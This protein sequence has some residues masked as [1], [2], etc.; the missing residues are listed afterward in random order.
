MAEFELFSE[1]LRDLERRGRS[2]V[3]RYEEVSPAVKHE[4]DKQLDN[5][6]NSYSSLHATAKQINVSHTLHH[7][8]GGCRISRTS[9][10][11]ITQR[12]RICIL[13][14]LYFVFVLQDR[15]RYGLKSSAR[16]GPS[17]LL[18]FNLYQ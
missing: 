15:R 4:V 3:E 5:I 10:C 14:F 11:R 17:A 7:I 2:Q 13:Y 16:A 1:S 6:R 12:R 18:H 9:A 8:G